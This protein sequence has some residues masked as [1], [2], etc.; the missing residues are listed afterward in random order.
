MLCWAFVF[1]GTAIIASLRGLGGL[2]STAAGIA[3]ALF[4]VF[5]VVFLV[6]L[7][8]GSVRQRRPAGDPEEAPEEAMDAPGEAADLLVAPSI[9]RKPFTAPDD[10]GGVRRRRAA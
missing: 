4:F 5:L 8:M 1:I 3:Q 9:R 2:A 10:R 6:A 7:V